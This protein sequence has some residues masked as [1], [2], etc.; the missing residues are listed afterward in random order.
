M[1]LIDFDNSYIT[2]LTKDNSYGRFSIDA[3]C[4][5]ENI[6]TGYI[7]NYYLLS[8]VMACNVY[9]TETLFHNPP[10]TFTAIFSKDKIKRIRNY[11]VQNTNNDDIKP[12][13]DVFKDVKYS[14]TSKEYKKAETVEDIINTTLENKKIIVV[15]KETT[16]SENIARYIFPVKHINVRKNPKKEFQIETGPI[17]IKK[18]KDKLLTLDNLNLA[19]IAFKD[20]KNLHYLQLDNA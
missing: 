16:N 15:I 6:K 3:I 5:M 7:Q 17:L 19:F 14:I 2:W 11:P 9:G 1:E 18:I 13:N 20:C 4:Q 12:I 10:Y 8:T